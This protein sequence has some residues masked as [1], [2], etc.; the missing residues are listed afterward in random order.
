MAEQFELN[1]EDIKPDSALESQ[2][3]DSLSIIE[4]M[5]NLED[6]FKINL[7]DERMELKTVQDI[8]NY[9]DKLIANQNSQA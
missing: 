1:I 9:I 6:V 2:G 3:L 5:F 4:F 8:A 7:P